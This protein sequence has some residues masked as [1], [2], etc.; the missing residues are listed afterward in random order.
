VVMATSQHFCGGTEESLKDPQNCNLP[1]VLCG[2]G[3]WSVNRK[4]ID[5]EQDEDV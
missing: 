4:I 1:V 2:W 3:T 5:S